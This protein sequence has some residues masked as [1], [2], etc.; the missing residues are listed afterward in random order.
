MVVVEGVAR[1]YDPNLNIWTESEPI[2]NDLNKLDFTNK[3][4]FSSDEVIN[5]AKEAIINL[6]NNI[7]GVK[8]NINQMGKMIDYQGVKIHPDSLNTIKRINS[9]FK[10]KSTKP[11]KMTAKQERKLKEIHLQAVIKQI[12]GHG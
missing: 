11:I 3:F 5:R 10:R 7:E 4:N 8:K 2:L 12:H 6:P 9:D 1:E